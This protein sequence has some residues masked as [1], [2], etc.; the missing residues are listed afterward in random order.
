MEKLYIKIKD[1]N[2]NWFED[3]FY[4]LNSKLI[5]LNFAGDSR[6]ILIHPLTKS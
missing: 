2:G 5:L 1:E 6:R 3:Q 4:I